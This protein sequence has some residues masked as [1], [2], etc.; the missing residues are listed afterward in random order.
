MPLFTAFK[1]PAADAQCAKRAKFRMN[2]RFVIITHTH[3]HAYIN[4]TSHGPHIKRHQPSNIMCYWNKK[5]LWHFFFLPYCKPI[6]GD[7]LL[8]PSIVGL[9]F[10]FWKKKKKL[11]CLSKIKPFSVHISILHTRY[12]SHIAPLGL[13]YVFHVF[14][15]QRRIL[16][17]CSHAHQKPS[18]LLVSGLCMCVRV[19][20]RARANAK[21]ETRNISNRRGCVR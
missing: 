16:C 12:C 10:G 17:V 13:C 18:G 4:Q 11:N 5:V 21:K 9:L 6:T 3:I 14:R 2:I 8:L 15:H 19:G 1:A 20:E 7:I